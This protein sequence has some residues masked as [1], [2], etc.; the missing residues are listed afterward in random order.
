MARPVALTPLRAAAARRMRRTAQALDE[1][2]P[3]TIAGD[4][5]R[6]AA[7]VLERGSADGAKRHL[8]AAMQLLTPQSLLRHGIRDDEGHATAKHHMHEVHRH[9]L[10]VQDIEDTAGSNDRLAAMARAARGQPEPMEPF[11]RQPPELLPA[12]AATGDHGNRVI[13]LKATAWE[14]EMRD[15][16]GKWA[17][18]PDFAPITSMFAPGG[19]HGFRGHSIGSQPEKGSVFGRHLSM[20]EALGAAEALGPG[21]P[22][23]VASAQMAER[24]GL[25]KFQRKVYDLLRKRG[26][27][28]YGAL[29]LARAT[30]PDVFRAG[31]FANSSPAVQL[32]FWEHERRNALGE[33]TTG[34][35]PH[36]APFGSNLRP[37][38][39]NHLRAI[40]DLSRLTGWNATDGRPSSDT[41]RNSLHHL[42]HA[43]ALRD[44]KSA[45]VHMASARWADEHE[46][47]G[48]YTPELDAIER[49]LGLVNVHRS[50]RWM[51]RSGGH[52][53][54]AY[55]RTG[56]PLEPTRGAMHVPV[57]EMMSNATELAAPFRY[58]H[59]WIKL[60]DASPLDGRV[61][62]A[63][64]AGGGRVAGVYDHATRTVQPRHTKRL[65]VTAVRKAGEVM[66]A[67]KTPRGLAKYR[68]AYG[69]YGLA[70][71]LSARTGALGTY[72]KTWVNGTTAT[73]T[74]GLGG[75]SARRAA[76]LAQIVAARRSTG[77]RSTAGMGR[78]LRTIGRSATP[79]TSPTT[80]VTLAS[81]TAGPGSLGTRLLRSEGGT[82]Q[83]RVATAPLPASTGSPGQ[84]LRTSSSTVIGLSARTPFLERT[85]APRGRPGGPGL[86]HVQG[87]GHTA[88]LQQ[89]VKALIEKRGM[90]PDK[91]Y[92]IARAAIR[93][94]AARSRHPEVRGAAT[95]AEAGEIARQARAKAHT[96][97]A[98]EVADVLIELAC[99]PI[100][101]FNP[102]HAP[103][104][105]GGGQFTTQQGAGQGQ[106][107][108][109]KAQRRAKLVKQ[110][111][112]LRRQIA[113]LRAQLPSTSP[114]K[115]GKPGKSKG[116]TPAKKGAGAQSAKQARQGKQ[117]A[118]TAAR[119]T[120][121]VATIHA[122]IAA[123]RA[124]LQADIAALRKL[125]NDQPAI[126][127]IGDGHG[128]HIPGTPDVYSHG[129][130][131]LAGTTIGPKGIRIPGSGG[132]PPKVASA[133]RVRAAVKA[134]RIT[135]PAVTPAATA[136]AAPKPSAGGTAGLAAAMSS[137]VKSRKE[138]GKAS[139]SGSQGLQGGT[140][141][142]TFNNG[143]QFVHKD[144]KYLP[145]PPGL[146][147]LQAQKEVLAAKISKALGA[148]A[149]DIIPDP[150][151]SPT[152][153][154]MAKIEGVSGM[155]KFNGPA[156]GLQGSDAAAAEKF[157]NSPEGK[158]I[159]LLDMII[160]HADRHLGNVMVTPD[161]KP[162][163]I[164]HNDT[165]GAVDLNGN[166]VTTSPFAA[167]LEK[168]MKAGNSP[169]SVDD[170]DR[171]TAQVKALQP[172]FGKLNFDA[173]SS[174]Y[175]MT[176]S[177]LAR[178]RKLVAK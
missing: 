2:H 11:H 159:G 76:I 48:A 51:R 58:R 39:L 3:E 156:S 69:A 125:A 20:H 26:R 93:K 165:W 45:R 37:G 135:R 175:S 84:P 160:G 10:A 157:F 91:A 95:R 168:Q 105:A 117:S 97:A 170:I 65:P 60:E 42:A 143:A 145:L 110:I 41:L 154:Y 152:S 96:A 67:A 72:T 32:A 68:A 92:A 161:G 30:T 87:M 22:K 7:R 64:A 111:A 171:I 130:R 81:A 78:A 25:P 134:A 34:A 169:F 89:V 73:V 151:G 163:P 101:L 8:D 40:E 54:H 138:P 136:P 31:T 148:G 79:A 146:Q 133:G 85:P 103:P 118:K 47:G 131:P 33:W 113:A 1:D 50:A 174:Y 71:E 9:H 36:Q 5:L 129:W 46:A 19:P 35:D 27:G 74:R 141:I 62:I 124:E 100:E 158:K 153:F 120:A 13:D 140:E 44:M 4:H 15:R 123:L 173:G 132:G 28:H 70:T 139:V 98:W 172:E 6:D 122:K 147:Q 178:I 59:G 155:E 150:G 94:W 83:E 142:V 115:P 102:Y 166:M 77:L 121:S 167:E 114:R 108:G 18:S 61:V 88:Y 82:R 164:D 107:K 126:E 112:S 55:G 75:T 80:A 99:E 116:S 66:S 86:Y 38:S 43:L 56:T 176:M 21:H 177:E 57:T 16:Y 12:I 63:K 106:A 23:Q 104:G 162:V 127:L 90:R 149:P 24:A 49:S 53:P 109:S 144:Y 52:G 29:V 137:G 119:K 128:H 17:A 14:R